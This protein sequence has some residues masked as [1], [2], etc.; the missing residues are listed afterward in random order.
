[1][2]PPP[3]VAACLAGAR[4]PWRACSRPGRAPRDRRPINVGDLRTWLTYIASDELEGRATFSAGLGLAAG[5]IQAHLQAVGRAAGGRRR[6]LSADGAGPRR[7]GD[8]PVD[9]SPFGSATRRARSR[10]A[11]AS[12]SRATPAASGPFTHRSRGVRR[13]RARC[14]GAGH[15]DFRGRS[16][17][18]AAVVFLGPTDPRP[19][20]R[21]P[22]RRLLAGRGRYATDQLRAASTIGP[23]APAGARR[24]AAATR[25]RRAARRR[26]S[27]RRSVST[28]R[29]RRP[30]R[31]RD[32]FFEFLFSRAPARYE[33]LQAQGRGPRAAALVRLDRRDAH[34][35]HRRRLRR[36][37]ARS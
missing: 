19:S 2:S 20:T 9:A 33:E 23:R 1:M 14:A 12:R 26:T 31:L 15:S 25:R 36:S 16:V 27:R 6:Y 7:H 13:L 3:S 34:V 4:S 29:C 8:Q 30:S 10:T 28:C 35:Q 22:Y 37:S 11:K 17:E 21:R 5:Y 18:G 24:R 32:E